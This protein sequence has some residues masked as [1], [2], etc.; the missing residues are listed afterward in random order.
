MLGHV[1]K[2]TDIYLAE[3]LQE[4]TAEPNA[5]GPGSTGSSEERN[6][7]EMGVEDLLK[8]AGDY[9]SEELQ[10][11]YRLSPA[12]GKLVPLLVA[13]HEKRD[14]FWPMGAD[15]FKSE[16]ANLK[17]CRADGRIVG[18]ELSTRRISGVVFERRAA[19]GTTAGGAR[20][21]DRH[22]RR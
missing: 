8:Y 2:I 19:S 12:E 1:Q 15:T 4:A 3:V 17:F 16:W 13:R 11:T 14:P 10:A 7:V 6:G 5:R 21:R 22:L 20:N 9:F 18:F